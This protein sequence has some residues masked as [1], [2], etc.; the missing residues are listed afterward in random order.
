M[1]LYANQYV[2]CKVHVLFQIFWSHALFGFVSEHQNTFEAKH[3]QIY[4]WHSQSEIKSF[5]VNF[6]PTINECS[7]TDFIE[8][9]Y[10]NISST[11]YSLVE[12]KMAKTT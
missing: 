9:S 6:I 7:A 10:E 1:F 12:M 8:V 3:N 4:I 5:S 11:V 2:E